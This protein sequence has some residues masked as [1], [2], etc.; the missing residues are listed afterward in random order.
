MPNAVA[1]GNM[2]GDGSSASQYFVIGMSGYHEHARGYIQAIQGQF[3]FRRARK[4]A[5]GLQR[6]PEKY[7][8]EQRRNALDFGHENAPTWVMWRVYQVSR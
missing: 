8:T 1:S 6:T 3:G 5:L 7:E 4:L 2:F